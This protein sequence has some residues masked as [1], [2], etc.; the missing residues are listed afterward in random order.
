MTRTAK[1]GRYGIF[2][3]HWL[4]LGF[5]LGTLTLMGPVRWAT[6]YTRAAGWSDAAEKFMVL[7]FIGLL[8]LVSLLAAR[9]LAARAAAGGRNTRY[10]LPALSLVLALGA[11]AAWLNPRLMIDPGAKTAGEKVAGTEFVF[12]PYPDK[13]RLAQLKK[14]GCTAVV[15]LLSRAVVPFEPVLLD[16][17]EAAAKEAGIELVHI[18]MLPWVSSNDNVGPA[19]ETLL[20]RGGRYYVHCYLGKD[21]VNVFKKRLEGLQ[22]GAAVS[23]AD[24]GTRRT[25]NDIKAFER[26]AITVLEKDVFFMPYPTDEEFFGY[27][28][29]GSVATLVSLLDPANPEN[30]PW[31]EKE[32]AA[33]DKYGLKLVSYPWLAMDAAAKRRAIA[34][35]KAL[36]RPLAAHAFISKAP[37]CADFMAYYR[38]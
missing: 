16:Q 13:D 10:G 17:E 27:V 15:P 21:R 33:A 38:K 19:L 4:C 30:R 35:I 31:M 12:G 2:F 36:P 3:F 1:L 22:A 34:A 28:L 20:A 29:N 14:E 37:E 18:P 23:I 11:L 6:N 32:K 25:L 26:G 8:A 5:F 9:L 7:G 24:G